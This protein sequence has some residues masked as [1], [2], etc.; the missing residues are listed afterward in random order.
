MTNWMLDCVEETSDTFVSGYCFRVENEHQK[1]CV[2]IPS[3]TIHEWKT[4][5]LVWQR[6]IH[7]HGK[8]WW[9]HLSS[10][11]YCITH[12]MSISLVSV[13]LST[14]R[15]L[16]IGCLICNGRLLSQIV[17]KR[18]II[19][20][21]DK[22]MLLEYLINMRYFWS[23]YPIIRIYLRVIVVIKHLKIYANMCNRTKVHSHTF[24]NEHECVRRLS[25]F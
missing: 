22:S 6:I 1:R 3:Y 23:V 8:L 14:E 7:R 13:L 5:S 16:N 15:S 10:L 19:K 20:R 11:Y 12:S 24:K 4:S 2:H 21:L 25:K 9:I 17:G 18:F